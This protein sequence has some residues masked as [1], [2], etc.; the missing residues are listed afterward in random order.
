[1]NNSVCLKWRV[2]NYRITFF[3][4]TVPIMDYLCYS[5]W[6]FTVLQFVWTIKSYSKPSIYYHFGRNKNSNFCIY[7]LGTIKFS[8]IW[9]WSSQESFCGVHVIYTWPFYFFFEG[10]VVLQSC[11]RPDASDFLLSLCLRLL[12]WERPVFKCIFWLHL[13]MNLYDKI[14]FLQMCIFVGS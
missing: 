11:A 13:S 6:L 9:V 4:W 10:Q 8:H 1:M 7:P 5:D 3:G 12:L 2:V 14:Y